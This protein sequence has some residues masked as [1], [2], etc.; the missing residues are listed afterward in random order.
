MTVSPDGETMIRDAGGYPLVPLLDSGS[1]LLD[2][3]LSPD[4]RHFFAITKDSVVIWKLDG[5]R[6]NA[7]RH[8]NIRKYEFSVDGSRLVTL[9]PKEVWVWSAGNNSLKDYHPKDAEENPMVFARFQEDHQHL[10]IG[11]DGAKRTSKGGNFLGFLRKKKK[12]ENAR[13]DYWDIDRDIEKSFVVSCDQLVDASVSLDGKFAVALE[14]GRASV[15]PAPKEK[16]RRW[17][18]NAKPIEVLRSGK[19]KDKLAQQVFSLPMVSISS[20]SLPAITGS[21]FS[22]AKGNWSMRMLSSGIT[23]VLTESS[24]PRTT[25][26]SSRINRMRS[27]TGIRKMTASHGPSFY[28]LDL[29]EKQAYGLT[30]FI[31]YI[32]GTKDSTKWWAIGILLLSMV[33]ALLYFSG[34]IIQFIQRKVTW[35]SDYTVQLLA[36]S[37]WY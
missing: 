14:P 30:T 1:G 8:P 5:V 21:S 26:T 19:D 12:Q 23:R 6:A 27:F 18:Y 37:H 2:I 32:P 3:G 24:L 10:I 36:C 13:I 7:Y 28:E 15:I 34:A 25:T 9:S 29:G 16:I 17:E 35:N 4:N 31:D 11:L 20:D 33:Y 22:I